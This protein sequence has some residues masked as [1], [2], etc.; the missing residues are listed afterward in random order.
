VTVQCGTASFPEDGSNAGALVGAARERLR[1]A[2][3]AHS[4]PVAPERPAPLPHRV[5]AIDPLMKQVFKLAERAAKAP[6]S[7]LVVG[8]TGT[9]KEVVA[10]AAVAAMAGELDGRRVVAA[11][12][13]RLAVAVL[14][15][16]LA[17][18]GVVAVA[19][20]AA[21]DD[22]G[23]GVGGARDELADAAGRGRAPGGED[24]ER[25]QRHQGA[26]ERGSKQHG[27]RK[28][29][30]RATEKARQIRTLEN[31]AH[32]GSRVR[33]AMRAV[34]ARQRRCEGQWRQ[35]AQIAGDLVQLRL[36][37]AAARS[38]GVRSRRDRPA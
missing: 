12:V 31:G 15:D 33:T 19:R 7:V 24:A 16:V 6:I 5:I 13:V 25:K 34:A 17:G 30:R 27:R 18:A 35:E 36:R 37:A 32:V 1:G 14:V 38:A 28:C 2:R 10:E 20:L 29:Q 23:A 11:V 21:L 4:E 22:A 8:E 3:T 9:G 26:G